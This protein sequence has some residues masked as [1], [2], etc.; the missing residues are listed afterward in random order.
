MSQ[1]LH[2]RRILQAAGA[3][4]ALPFLPSMWSSKARAAMRTEPNRLLVYTIANGLNVGLDE[5]P[6]NPDPRGVLSPLAHLQDRGSVITGLRMVPMARSQDHEY[7]L[8]CLLTDVEVS[9]MNSLPYDCGIS[10]DQVAAAQIGQDTPFPS[11]QLAISTPFQP[12]TP[13]GYVYATRMSWASETTPLPPIEQPRQLF[14]QM[15]AG[16]DPGATQEQ[17]DRRARL[18]RSVLD[19]MLSSVSSLETKLNAPD[20]LKLDQYTTS[21]RELERRID[22]LE[23]NTCPVP[24]APGGQLDLENSIQAFVELMVVALQCDLTRVIT[25]LSSPTSGQA[26]YPFL[27]IT[28]N[29]HTLSHEFVPGG[30]SP[31]IRDLMTIQRWHVGVFA[32]LADRLAEIPVGENDD[33]LLSKT[34]LVLNSEFT[35]PSYHSAWPVPFVLVGGEAGGVVQGRPLHFPSGTPHSNLLRSMIKFTGADETD[36]GT[37]ATETIDLSQP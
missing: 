9:R 37:T 21:V 1:R 18:K 32:G 3:S 15:F 24:E 13:N 4:L 14:D 36:F 17:I 26:T 7:S 2:R 35:D 11:M 8:P 20:R 33:D 31:S 23:E 30:Q 27:G 10:C 25:F 5:D 12:I 29:H 22:Q 16:V 6:D 28:G 19:G 34:L